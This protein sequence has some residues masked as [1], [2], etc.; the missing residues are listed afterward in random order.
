M[1]TQPKFS[2]RRRTVRKGDD[3]SSCVVLLCERR[4]W[5]DSKLNFALHVQ[6]QRVETTTLLAVRYPLNSQK[7]RALWYGTNCSCTRRPYD[8]LPCLAYQNCSDSFEGV[9]DHSKQDH[10]TSSGSTDANTNGWY[11]RD[12]ESSHNCEILGWAFEALWREVLGFGGFTNQR[13]GGG[14]R[15]ESRTYLIRVAGQQDNVRRK[16]AATVIHGGGETAPGIY[17]FW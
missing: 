2:G 16:A 13:I 9:A 15:T 10:Q 11:L 14:T 5:F 4:I 7:F 12:Y 6:M 17:R 1:K 8:R 3:H